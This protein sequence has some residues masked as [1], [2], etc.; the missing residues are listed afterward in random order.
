M[1][2]GAKSTL[3]LHVTPGCSEKETLQSTGVPEPGTCLK[4]E[5]VKTS[6]GP[7]AV[8]VW[9]PMF[10]KVTNWAAL[11]LP[12]NRGG[13]AQRGR[14]RLIDLDNRG[15]AIGGDED[16]SCRIDGDLGW[17]VCPTTP[18]ENLAVRRCA[19][20]RNLYDSACVDLAFNC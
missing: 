3:G 6:P 4:S 12:N 9:L 5:S 13:K 18:Q 11:E 16:L 8:S 19:T 1:L 10:C 15:S 17:V 14:L 20:R 2:N 7:A